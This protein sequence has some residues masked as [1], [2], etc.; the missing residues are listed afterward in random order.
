MCFLIVAATTETRTQPPVRRH[1]TV[2][3][4]IRL[5]QGPGRHRARHRV[6]AEGCQPVEDVLLELL[7]IAN[8]AY[9]D[10]KGLILDPLNAKSREPE[11]PRDLT[12][13][14]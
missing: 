11:G 6:L 10:R 12:R 2:G 4:L 9:R 7:L 14:L 13:G 8:I 1:H 5:L 3:D